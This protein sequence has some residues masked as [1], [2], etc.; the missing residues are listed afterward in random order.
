MAPKR[1]NMIPNGHFHKDWQRFVK[2]W[3]NQPAR[4]LRRRQN[5]IKKARAIAPRPAAGPLR[6]IV[7]CPTV[8]YHRKL[9]AGRGFTLD[10]IKGAGL[11]AG[12][13]RSVGISVD[14]RRR[15]K[16]VESLQQNVQRLKE[17]RSKLILFP[18]HPNK[19]IKKGEASEE[20]R[21]M[22]TQ[23]KTTVM[24]I[25]Q[26]AVRPRSRKVTE[27]EKKFSAFATLRKAR[28]DARLVGIR[29]KRLK[30]AAENPDV[31]AKPGKEGKK[32]K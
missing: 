19:K 27:E 29:A 20:E 14:H 15:N 7:R 3:F 22:A 5:R 1:N 13:A 10:E 28:T 6:P 8:R 21:K 26:P 24:P 16:S 17:Y 12:F 4:K 32:K 18:I 9:R 11:S 31:V 30:D 2:T 25:K 23:L